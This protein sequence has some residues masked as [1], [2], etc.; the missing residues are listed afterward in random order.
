MKIVKIIAGIILSL[1]IIFGLYVAFMTLT[2]YKP[3]KI[4][5]LDIENN[6][7][8]A[9]DKNE[10]LSVLTYNIGYCGLDEE[11][12]FFMDG[13]KESR[14][15]SKEKTI[16]NLNNIT[17]FVNKNNN[18]FILLQEV[19]INSTRSY[20]VNQYEYMKEELADTY[21]STFGYNYKAPWVPLPV[22][23]P[24]GKVEAG[25]VTFSKYNI[26]ES[27]RYQ[28][29]GEYSWPKQLAMLDRCFTENRIQLEDEKELVIINSHLSA[30]DKGGVI[31]KQ[32]LEFLRNYLIEEYHKGNYIVVGGDWNHVIPGTEDNEFK[33]EQEWPEW[34]NKIPD[35]FKP[36]GFKWAADK[37]VASNRTLNIPY[38]KG[39]NYL[40]V[41]DGFLVSPNIDIIEIKGD[42]CEFKYSDHNPVIMKFKLK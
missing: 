26:K 31:R 20:K 28:Y 24:H 17:E 33:S 34:L 2:D 40:S 21:C 6:T 14:G 4:I 15:E 23:K 9:I 42:D 39:K 35:N 11:R 22:L 16:D 5:T 7:K 29:P 3:D 19:D 41:I 36:E 38:K 1:L 18:D 30:Y 37:T 13:G 27:A 25:L 8:K 10:V 12:D 32:Q